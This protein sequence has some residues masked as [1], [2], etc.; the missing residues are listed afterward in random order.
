[1]PT[2]LIGGGSPVSG[3]GRYIRI[4]KHQAA[5]VVDEGAGER[6]RGR[7]KVTGSV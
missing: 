5:V 2:A 4:V 3:R 1:M 7:A 6:E